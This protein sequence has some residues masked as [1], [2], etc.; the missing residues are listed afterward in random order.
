MGLLQELPAPDARPVCLED[1]CGNC[2]FVKDGK[3]KVQIM[4]QK[5]CHEKFRTPT[6]GTFASAWITHG[7]APKAGSY[8]Y[9]VWIQPSEKELKTHVPTATYKV[10]QRNYK[11]HAVKDVLTGIMAYAIF[12][13]TRPTADDVFSFLPAETMVMYQ[14]ENNTLVMSVCAP[15]LNIVEKTFTTKEPSRII[16]KQLELKGKWHVSAS[17]KRVKT[18]CQTDKTL[19]SVECQHGQPV[20]FILVQ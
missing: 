17:D 15:D 19:V 9:M 13:N 1:G 18:T 16:I 20:E 11:M 10:V 2:Y 4:E 6:T 7:T 14:N 12:E 3:V 5:S 8:E